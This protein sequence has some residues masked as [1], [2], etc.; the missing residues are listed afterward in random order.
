MT[1]WTLQL[2]YTTAARKNIPPIETEIVLDALANPERI[3]RLI[4]DFL[5]REAGKY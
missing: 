5:E 4:L 3:N 1:F 2:P